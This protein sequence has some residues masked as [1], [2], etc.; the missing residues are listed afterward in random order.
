MPD[1]LVLDQGPEFRSNDLEAALAYLEVHKVERPASRPRF[2]A[3]V[4]RIFG[5]INTD[6]IHELFGH[7]KLVSLGRGLSSSHHPS[8]HAAWTLPLLQSVLEEWLF[9]LYPGRVHGTL[10]ETPRAVFE[11]S[12]ARD[13]ER[14][15]RYVADDLALQILLAQTP[16]GV[17]RHVDRD[18]GIVLTYLPYWHDDFQYEDIVGTDV[19]VKV[20]L[21]DTSTVFARVR[22]RWVV[23]RLTAGDADLHGR[24]WRQIR[25]VVETLRQQRREGRRRRIDAHAIG[26]FLRRVDHT[27]DLA[28]QIARDAERVAPPPPPPSPSPP[29]LRVVAASAHPSDPGAGPPLSGSRVVDASEIDFTT[30]EPFEVG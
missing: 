10:G 28:R 17:T 7:S 9:G 29:A 6:W 4:E 30:L 15:A 1:S 13:G 14:V 8:R 26:E 11:A 25:L 27:G 2:G 18:R 5:V 23:C 22:G 20:Q 24:S 16:R 21:A 12:L 19:P 3:V